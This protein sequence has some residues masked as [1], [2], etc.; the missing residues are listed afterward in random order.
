VRALNTASKK[1]VLSKLERVILIDG[2]KSNNL[3]W[4][5]LVMSLEQDLIELTRRAERV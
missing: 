1:V 2:N 5:S 4:R 3:S